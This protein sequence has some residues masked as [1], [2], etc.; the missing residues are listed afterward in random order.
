[1][2]PPPHPRL[3]EILKPA[4]HI[5]VFT[6]AGISTGSGIPD[7]RGP[8]GIWKTRQPVYYDEFMSSETARI[9]YW[10]FK[11]ETWELYRTALPNPAHMA[12]ARI[13]AAGRV[14]AVVTQNIDGLHELAGTSRAKL[15]EI[16]GTDRW[17]A[18]QSCGAL[19]EPEAHFKAFV[20]TRKP[21][22]CHCG[23]FLKPATISF[24]QSLREEDLQRAALAAQRADLVL[25]LGSTLSVYP[26]AHF[27]LAAAERGIPYAIIN[28]GETEH[29]NHPNLTLRI[30]G[31]VTSILPPTVDAALA[32]GC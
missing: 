32:I 17:I 22:R 14:E 24:G 29:D 31:D 4:R 9:E 7:Y 12:I 28:R 3:V 5:L 2:P 19:S 23:G 30:E 25:A 6:G 16:H 26:A 20:Q 15:V 13:E 8:Q 21:P 11:L 27:P 10:D 18:C 1:M